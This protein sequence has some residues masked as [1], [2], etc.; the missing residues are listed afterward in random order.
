M[1]SSLSKKIQ[2]IRGKGAIKIGESTSVE[3]GAHVAIKLGG[4]IRIGDKCS[5]RR[6]ALIYS[7]RGDISIGDRCSVNPYSILYGAGGLRIGN[8]VRIAAHAVIIPSQHIFDDPTKTIKQQG[9]RQIGI[10]IEDDVWI[11]AHVTVLD[12][13]H[14]TK[15][16][17]IGAGS[18]V[19]G[20]TRP[21]GI[22]VGSPA[23]LIGIR[24]LEKGAKLD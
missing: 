5:I 23:K 1:L 2:L 14:I 22:Y 11:G 21:F 15:G 12:G 16:C 18:V 13:A 8:D 4:H 19:R 24:G 10:T 17:V 7:F 20:K 6:G 3:F 9:D